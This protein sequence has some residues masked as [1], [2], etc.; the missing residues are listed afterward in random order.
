MLLESLGLLGYL[1]YWVTW[2]IGLLG[3]VELLG[4]TQCIVDKNIF[5]KNLFGDIVEFF[6]KPWDESLLEYFP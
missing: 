1:G 5:R 2:V 4:L 6:K 3:S